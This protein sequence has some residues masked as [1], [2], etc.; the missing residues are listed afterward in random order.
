VSKK[1]P[2]DNR[3]TEAMKINNITEEES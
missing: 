3:E 2:E 1:P